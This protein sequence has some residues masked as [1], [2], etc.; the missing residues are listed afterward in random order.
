[1]EGVV[2][3]AAA[4]GFL[5]L[6]A[7][8]RERAHTV[9]WLS[10]HRP[11]PAQLRALRRALGSFN[12][13]VYDRPL[14][15]AEDAIRLAKRLGADVIV[16]V[17]PL[18]FI[19]RLCELARKEGVLLLWAEM[20]LL[21]MCAGESCPAYDPERDAVVQSREMDTGKTTYRHFRFS[22]FRRIVDVRLELEDL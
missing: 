15:T 8:E 21:H 17:L 22:R 19:A 20:E 5:E 11:L 16:P 4:V 13:H 6:A 14:S 12:L 2:D 18:S 1:M 3:K 10:R 7:K 9:L